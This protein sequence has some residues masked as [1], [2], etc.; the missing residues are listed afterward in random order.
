[1]NGVSDGYAAQRAILAVVNAEQLRQRAAWVERVE[2]AAASGATVQTVAA[3]SGIAR[4]AVT[5]RLRR[6]GRRDVIAAMVANARPQTQAATVTRMSAIA[7]RRT[8]FV[9]DA[10]WMAETG[11]TVEGA[12]ARF[13]TAPH[14]L[15]DR[16]GKLDRLDLWEAFR[17]NAATGT[18][19]RAGRIASPLRGAA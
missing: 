4:K 11:E 13:G 1:M 10:E 16:L 3:E 15:R 2:A 12:A 14:T 19:V 17:A 8:A 6:A 9:E 18:G 7:A 5:A